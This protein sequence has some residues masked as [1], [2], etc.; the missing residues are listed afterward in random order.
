[1]AASA[2]ALVGFAIAI[3]PQL[4]AKIEGRRTA[5]VGRLSYIRFVSRLDGAS[6]RIWST[7]GDSTFFI[8][9]YSGIS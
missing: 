8:E 9:A 5:A 1:M 3:S 2:S 7:R 6:M 4:F